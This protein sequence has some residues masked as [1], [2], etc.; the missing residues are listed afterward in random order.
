MPVEV[1]DP[2]RVF[3]EQE[4]IAAKALDQIAAMVGLAQ[5]FAKTRL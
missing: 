4:E 5:A 1:M 2:Q 3:E